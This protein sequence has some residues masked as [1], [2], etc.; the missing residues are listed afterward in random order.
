[1]RKTKTSI[2]SALLATLLLAACTTPAG[3][4]D[5]GIKAPALWNRLTG[6]SQTA[7]PAASLEAPL[8]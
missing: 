1:M 3:P 5:S 6:Q 4:Q 8:V 2:V 7:S